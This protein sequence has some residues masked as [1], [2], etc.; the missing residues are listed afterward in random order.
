MQ[1]ICSSCFSFGWNCVPLLFDILQEM[2]VGDK[3]ICKVIKQL[4]LGG[5]STVQFGLSNMLVNICNAYDVEE[6]SEEKEAMKKIGKY[7]GEHI[8]EAHALDADEFVEKRVSLLVTKHK[9]ASAMVALAATESDRAREQVARVFRAMAE[10]KEHRGI[11]LSEGAAK[12][13]VKLA[14]QNTDKGKIKA[15]HALA[16]LA[17]TSNPTLAFPG[18]RA[19]EMCRPLLAL[20]REDDRRQQFEGLMALTNLT[21]ESDDLRMRVVRENGI[22]TCEDLMYDED[23]LVRRAATE[24]MCNMFNCEKVYEMFAHPPPEKTE[25]QIQEEK[26]KSKKKPDP[27]KKLDTAGTCFSRLKLWV[28]LSGCAHEDYATGVAA[29]GGLAV[30]S[31]S[32]DVCKQIQKE[33]QGMKILHENAVSMDVELQ[34]RSLYIQCNMCRHSKEMAAVVA[35]GHGLNMIG[36]LHEV[37]KE[38]GIV[39]L[40]KQILEILE[41]RKIIEDV[42][43]AIQTAREKA[44]ETVAALARQDEEEEE[45]EEE[46]V[47]EADPDFSK[48]VAWPGAEPY[49]P[50]DETD[51]SDE[52]IAAKKS[53]AERIAATRVANADLPSAEEL[54]QLAE[55]D[56]DHEAKMAM[57]AA[58]DVTF[59]EAEKP[60]TVDGCA[61]ASNPHHF[62]SE[63][64][65]TVVADRL[66]GIAAKAAMAASGA[67]AEESPKVEE[68]LDEEQQT[69][70]REQ[71]Q[72]EALQT[73]MLA[74]AGASKMAA[75]IKGDAT[76]K[77]EGEYLEV[78]DAEKPPASVE[79]DID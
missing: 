54:K 39:D 25:E 10:K 11:L 76:S 72:R 51:E 49:I 12:V 31:S 14:D 60:P 29:S 47:E 17:I 3:K 8:P 67:D 5:D 37:S 75:D 53:Y 64:C 58:G 33:K 15:A 45:E 40:C 2:I 34:R 59:K 56:A 32:E 43:S 66:A 71:A 26:S 50:E 9:L 57:P 13:L 44:G 52:R 41:D 62:C 55:A 74:A 16:L 1:Q 7:A 65:K 30:L 23:W 20:I 77:K 46:E 4:C 73:V 36:A 42:D 61:N 48:K 63:F 18:Q 28:L 19:A 68:V 24:V 21:C 35:E 22:N 69:K 79:L 27:K 78:G 38:K 6:K 70:D